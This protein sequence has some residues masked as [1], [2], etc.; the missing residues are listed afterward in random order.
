[1]RGFFMPGGLEMDKAWNDDFAARLMHNE[2]MRLRMYH[3]S[4]GIPTVGVGFNLTRADWQH[5][6]VTAGVPLGETGSVRLGALPLTVAQVQALLNYSDAPT[7]P[8]AR[9]LLEPTHF[10]TWLSPARQCAFADLTFNMG[11]AEL[12]TFDALLGWIDGACHLL[13]TGDGP[14]AH[15]EFARAAADLRNTAYASQ[16]GARAQRNAAMLELSTYVPIDA[17]ES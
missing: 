17:F 5:A 11:E 8:Q 12:A 1:M 10:D 15:I 13:A 16:V 3:D 6:L 14:G 2:G 7:I 9:S 4:L